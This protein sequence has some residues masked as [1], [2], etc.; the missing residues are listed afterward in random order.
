MLYK[1]ADDKSGPSIKEGDFIAFNFTIKNDADS[2]MQTSVGKGMPQT[3]P[4][5]KVVAGKG[6]IMEVFSY[7]SEGDSVIIKQDID[8]LTKGRKR[9]P[10]LKGKYIVYEVRIDKVI[11]KGNLSEQVFQGRVQDYMKKLVDGV[12]AKEPVAI[13]KYIGDNKLKVTTTASGLNYVIT[14]PGQGP[15]PAA[16]DTAVV[17]YT[18]KFLDGK[19]VE[20][21]VKDVAVKNKMQIN[22]MNPYKPLRFPLGT[23][24]M[25]PAW[26][27]GF[28]LFNKGTKATMIVPSSLAYGEQ[29]SRE[30]GPYTPLVFEVELVDIVHP[31]PNTPKPAQLPPPTVKQVK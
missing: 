30:I 11:A 6:N 21:S 1:I 4:M 19:V 29:G 27:E 22:P 26:N 20:T 12:K 28:L 8:T 16:G 5:P 18:V 10:N 31:N 23:P 25:I 14:T 17:H 24:G 2:V 9:P 15:T 7:L 13:K 3:A